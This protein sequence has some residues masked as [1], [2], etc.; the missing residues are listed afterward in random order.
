MKFPPIAVVGQGCVLP[1]A[2]SPEALWTLVRAGRC[3]ITRAEKGSWRLKDIVDKNQLALEIA[4]DAGG[5]VRDF[6]GAF[7]PSGFLIPGDRLRGLDP[8]FLWTLHAAREALRSAGLDVGRTHPRGT[9][10]LGNLSYPTTALVDM[11][12]AVWEKR[13]AIVD[14]RNRFMSG[15]PAQLIAQALGFGGRA[16]ALDAACAS[17]LYAVK[18][19]CDCLHDGTADLALAGGVNHADDLFLHLGFTALAALSPSG[20]SRPFHKEADGLVPAQGAAVVVLKRLVDA[21]RAGDRVLGVIRGVGLSNDGHSRGLLVPS[22]EGQVRAMRAA[23]AMSGLSPADVS[24]VECHATGTRLGDAAELCSLR[25]VF[26][27]A[28]DVPIGSLKSNLGHLVTAS[29]TAG[30]IKV[31]GAMQAGVRPPT[32]AAGDRHEATL[33]G[34]LRVLHTEEPWTHAG[35]GPRL[36]AIN[37]FGFGGN[38]AHLLV[39]EWHPSAAPRVKLESPAFVVEIA[40]IAQAVTAGAAATT[41]EFVERLLSGV[42]GTAPERF[43]MDLAGMRVPPADLEEALPQQLLMVRAALQLAATIDELP[44]ERTAVLVGMQVDPE[45]ARYCL[46]WRRN[47]AHPGGPAERPLTAASVVGCMPNVVANRLSHQLDLKAPCFTLSADEASGTIALELAARSL[48]A[49]EIDAA[50]VG[51]VDLCCEPVQGAAAN[52]LLPEKQRASGDAAVLFVLKRLDDA[53]RAGDRVLAI[54]T[55]PTTAVPGLSFRPGADTSVMSQLFGHA[56]AASGLLHVAAA[57][58]ACQHRTLPPR[59]GRPAMPWLPTRGARIA[60]VEVTALGGTHTDTW[61]RADDSERVHPSL[62]SPRLAVFGAAD[63]TGLV[64][65]LARNQPSAQVMDTFRVSIVAQSDEEL[66]ARIDRASRL[67]R[68][69]T[70][71]A[72][73]ATLGE[74][75][76]FGMGALPGEVAFVFTGPAGGYSGM[77]RELALAL[78]E[79]VESLAARSG[80]MRDAVGWVYDEGPAYHATP[81]EKLWGSSYLIQLHA[82][83]TRGLLGIR[84]HASIGYCSGET[85]ALFA[86]GAWQDLD[87][88]Q[89]AIDEAKVY[90]H[91][92]AGELRCVRRAWN[93]PEPEAVGW[94][95]MRIRAPLADVRAAIANEAERRVHLTI[96]NGPTDSVVA[97]EPAA[98]A[99]VTARLGSI[100]ART[101]DYDFVMHCPEARSFS[102]AWRALHHRPTAQVPGVRFYTHATCA[103][104]A[105][106]ADAVADAL[107]GQAMQL[108]DFPALIERAWSDGVRVFIEHGPHGACT[109][110]IGDTLGHRQHL[111]V[112]LDSYGRSSLLQTLE[113]V[114][115]LV[116]AGVPLNHQV[117]SRRLGPASIPAIAISELPPA[118]QS[119]PLHFAPHPQTVRFQAD[120]P[121]LREAVQV[122]A[123]PPP[124]PPIR[125]RTRIEAVRWPTTASEAHTAA[126]FAS[127]VR[128]APGVFVPGDVAVASGLEQVAQLHRLFL[129]QQAEVHARFLCVAFPELMASPSS[130]G[131]AGA[132]SAVH[133]A[134]PLLRSP[135]GPHYD[136]AELEVLASGE[137]SSVFGP[138]FERQDSFARQVRMPMP[139]LLL[140][141]RVTGIEGEPGMLGV[142]TIWTETDVKADAW[143]LHEGRMPTGIL[144][145]SGQADLMLISW[146]GIDLENRGERVYRLLGCDLTVHGELP[147][148]GDTLAYEIHIDG[149]AHEGDVH[150]FFFHYD[151]RVDGVLRVSVRGGQAGFFTDDELGSSTGLLWSAEEATA[152]AEAQLDSPAVICAKDHLSVDEIGAFAGGRTHECFGAGFERAD[153]HT[154]TPAIQGGRM[155]LVDEVLQLEP[156][157]G[158]WRRGYLRAC[159]AVTAESWFFDGHFKNDPCMPGTLMFEGCLQ[160]MSIY[161]AALGYTLERDG[162]RFEPVTG[163]SYP[164]RCRGQVTPTSKQLVYEVFVD[165]VIAGPIPT[166]YADLLC[167]VDGLKAFHCRRMGLKLVPSWPLEDGRMQ[168]APRND[169]KPVARVGDFAFGYDSLLACAW[170]RPSRAFG[171][172]YERFDGH[173]R[174]ARLPGPPYHFITRVTRVDG[175]IGRMQPQSSVVAEYDVPNDAWYFEENGARVMPFCVLLE[176]ALQP[177]GWLAS[178]IGSALTSAADLVF[179]NL[180]GAGTVH[181]EVFDDVG[182]LTITAKVKSLSTAGGLIVLAFDVAVRAGE[183]IVYRLE[184]VFGFFTGDMMA[185]QAGLPTTPEEHAALVESSQV[186][187]QLDE[188]A[189]TPA[190]AFASTL[191]LGRDKLRLID[192]IT[193]LW[194]TGGKAGLGR[195]RVEKDIAAADWFFKAHFFQDPVQPGSLGIETMLQALQVMMIDCGLSEGISGPR[196]EAC[197]LEK[198]MTWKYRG[199]VGPDNRVVVVDMELT[200]IGAD[201]RGRFVVASGSLWVDG[202]Q[203][204]RVQGVGMR[205]VGSMEIVLDPAIDTWLADHRPTYTSPALPMMGI[206]DL[207]AGAAAAAR[208]GS[209]LVAVEALSVSD[210]VVVDRRRRLVTVVEPVTKHPDRVRVTL[211]GEK[212]GA[213]DLATAIVRLASAYPDRPATSSLPPLAR[214]EPMVDPYESGALFHGPAFHVLVRGERG[215]NGGRGILDAGRGHVP[216]GTIAPLLLDGALHLVPHDALEAWSHEAAIDFIGFPTQ[217]E[218]LELFGPAPLQ[219]EVAVEIRC[220]GPGVSPRHVVLRAELFAGDRLWA[221]MRLVEILLPKGRL[222][223]APGRDRRAFLRDR[224][225]VAGL[226]ISHFAASVTR[227]S[228]AALREADWLP[229][230]V[231]AVYGI[232]PVTAADI[233][234]MTLEVAVKDHVAQATGVHPSTVDVESARCTLNL[235]REEN[236]CVVIRSA[237]ADARGSSQLELPHGVVE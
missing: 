200:A 145:E 45:I 95:A 103:S 159:F 154:R 28:S 173:R 128:A 84:P 60:R 150:L 206:A 221:R 165:E 134:P 235:Q 223:R 65:A 20:R 33:S 8:V 121:R 120:A 111:A 58:V 47:G 194:P 144:V 97:G 143:Y 113:S 183:Q 203:I 233:A 110:W 229:G 25:E 79:L 130:A 6:E 182:T 211:R 133:S 149:H 109:K 152:R 90:S 116:A 202:K 73:F 225:P 78:P 54:L 217:L 135:V 137:I 187:Y 220:A 158:P 59:G 139:P 115:R 7:D 19:A 155:R 51:A 46:R 10:V 29:G 131:P 88:F 57:V 146:Q 147:R 190:R 222:G 107:T 213:A 163:Q 234:A 126:G 62:K 31:L 85:N 30:L 171:E 2:L 42:A 76:Y 177:C 23:Y 180:D 49:G 215:T 83:L 82:E 166:L 122:M 236:G 3:E 136:R 237:A 184:T 98:C 5:Y 22:V 132:G 157:G 96:I 210:W 67:L 75:I 195:I 214:P 32:L 56:H 212:D 104:Y 174:V 181:G 52:V 40:V 160:A 129:R 228:P 81:A 205:I 219:G 119:L 12:L 74:G 24:L 208:P 162:W 35:P 232:A 199:Q 169:A 72:G 153:T 77:G 17:S 123:R 204:Y 185:S 179:R 192:R 186:C 156:A 43:E 89:R 13:P 92:L 196:F 11:A 70:D 148:V 209:V 50:L 87:G 100:R 201:E 71:V 142:G 172:T 63:R 188:V 15:L 14:P 207:L 112:A 161:V 105:P 127:E 189:H 34:P 176:V 26:A 193:G 124:T 61:L 108:I 117:L 41:T 138:R 140:A 68:T 198:P 101:L 227:L 170:G 175:E 114:A 66:A 38:N 69:Q 125:R 36:A 91:E 178:Y 37:N 44:H 226:G 99:R 230:T 86:L 151:C 1:G 197:A 118:R 231:A 141:D 9:V 48:R 18:L 218:L 224:E 167:T 4:S 21:E 64:R 94:T 106:T 191:R 55:P 39:E 16:F 27:E 168:L 80:S 102:S 164:L 216:R 93:V 53:R